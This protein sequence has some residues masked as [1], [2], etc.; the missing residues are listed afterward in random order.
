MKGEERQRKG[1]KKEREG[2]K[3]EDRWTIL[4]DCDEMDKDEEGKR[5][6]NERKM[7]QPY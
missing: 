6:V 7:V 1:K 5:V 4:G 2:V 3:G